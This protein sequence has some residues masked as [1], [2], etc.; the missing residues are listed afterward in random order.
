MTTRSMVCVAAAV[1]LAACSAGVKSPSAGG[2]GTSGGGMTGTGGRGGITGAG[3]TGAPGL[4]G[5][6][7]DIATAE[8]GGPDSAC[9]SMPTLAQ[10]VPLDLYV[11]MDSSLSMNETTTAGTSKW[12]D[13][14]TAMGT[15]FDNSPGLG[16][17]LKFFPGVQSGVPESCTGDG[18]DQA[19]GNFG[20]C[21]RRKTCV[22]NMGTTTNPL[23]LCT[24]AATCGTGACALVQECP[25]PPVTYCAEGPMAAATNACDPCRTFNGYCHLRDICMPNF[26]ATPDVTVG[27]LPLAAQGLKNALMAKSPAGYTPT[28][29]ALTGALMFARQRLTSMPTRRIAVVLVTDGLPGGF[30]TG[31]PPAECTPSDV[32]GI[33]TLASGPQGAGGAPPILTFV[34]GVFAP[35]MAAQTAQTNLDMLAT[36]GGT[37]PAVVINTGQDVTAALQ[38]ALKSVQSKAIACE[39]QVPSQGVD[40]KKVNVQFTNGAGTTVT[41]IGH[42]PIDGT[43]GSGCDARGG[44]YYDRDPMSGAPTKITACPATCTML[45][46]D[47]DGKVDVVLGCPTI[48]VG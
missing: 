4:D 6:L 42:A 25:G 45:Q 46:T 28:G 8:T 15:F 23:P 20:P 26:Y 17:G 24:S 21:D 12:N 34:I 38:N 14:R 27:M 9:F 3:G 1:A 13:V 44:W 18:V 19:C 29:P 30:L 36:A 47:L 32:A 35:G 11:L 43:D 5:G 31:I 10:P 37:A 2:A 33:A 7:P 22:G 41:P 39:Y 16:V 40:F 48:D